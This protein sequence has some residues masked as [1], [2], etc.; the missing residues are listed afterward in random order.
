METLDIGNE[1]IDD[2]PVLLY[3]LQKMGIQRVVDEHIPRHGNWQGLSKGWITVIWLSY[4]LSEADHRMVVV[5]DWV[6]SKERLLCELCG[7]EVS[8]LDFTDDR[9]AAVLEALSRDAWWAAIEVALGQHLIQVYDLRKAPIRVD[10]TSVSVHHTVKD[11]GLFQFGYSKDRRPDLAQ[12]KVMLSTL[13]PM[14]L[15]LA[16]LI[17]PGQESDERAYLPTIERTRQI[18]GCG[19]YLYIGDSKMSALALR[20]AIAQVAD[21]Y[22]VPLPRRHQGKD[23]LSDWY[24]PVLDKEQVL[25]AVDLPTAQTLWALGYESQREQSITIGD[26]T[27]TWSERVIMVFRPALARQERA[28]LRQRLDRAQAE[29]RQLAPKRLRAE[30]RWESQAAMQAAAQLILKKYRVADLLAV[31]CSRGEEQRLIRKYGD[32]PAR[33]EI[34]IRE[35]ITIQPDSNAIRATR[36]LLGW[37]LYVTN[38]PSPQLPLEKALLTYRDAPR[39]EL[40]WRRLK[41]RS[42]GLR[43]VFTQRE[44][45]TIGLARLLTLALRV[46]T[47]TDFVVREALQQQGLSLKGL[48][49]GQPQRATDQPTTERLL[50]AF[51]GIDRV[52]IQTPHTLIRHVTPLSPLQ[53]QI[54][55]LLGLAPELYDALVQASRAR[56]P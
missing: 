34:R 12:F 52:L 2:I 20:G 47:L 1:R 11:E 10:S 29:L 51:K 44:D 30:P 4:I 53:Y 37:R 36:Q 40:D 31:N 38:A 48:Y 42:L 27:F 41:G 13:D 16:S 15:P 21:F 56:P 24:Q 43:P 45:H 22:L 17:P 55:N 18:V 25:Q 19:G 5:R 6:A 32:R 26:E 54:L 49:P 46:L 8:A 23:Q 39:I 50:K 9:L 33:T 14:G 3:Q 28:N 35:G 7:C